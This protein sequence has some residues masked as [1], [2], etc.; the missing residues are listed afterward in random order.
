MKSTVWLTHFSGILAIVSTLMGQQSP[1]NSERGAVSTYCNPLAI[2]DYPIGKRC[3]DIVV[4]APQPNNSLWLLDHMEQYRELADV[5]VLWHEGKWYMYPSVDMAWVSSDGGATWEHHPLNVRDIGYAPTVVRHKGKF[6][7]L[8]SGSPIYTSDSPL[9]PFIELGKI[10]VPQGLPNQTDPMLFS[11][12]DGRLYYYWG[13]TAVGGIY[14]VELDADNPT[15]IAGTPVRLV[16]RFEPERFP[17]QRLGDWNEDANA[18]YIEGAWLLKRNGTYYLTYSAGGTENRTYAVGCLTSKAPLGPFTPQKDNP[19]MRN[20]N[21]LVTGTAHGS[22]VEGP[23]NSLWAFYTLRAGAVHGWERRLGMDPAYISED[24]E[25]HVKPAS[26]LP[27]R[28]TS[29]NQGAEPTGWVPL[30]ANRRSGAT[31]TAANLSTRL[32]VDDDL[33][34]WWQPEA[35]DKAPALTTALVGNATVHAIRIVW[36]DVGINTMKGASPGAFRYKVE[37]QTAPNTWTTVIDRSDSKDDLLIDYR[38]CAPTKGNSARLVIVGAPDGIT[39]G[40]AEF[41]V[42]GQALRR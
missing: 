16:D 23:N 39:P 17:W 19:I 24:G 15:R 25:L 38:E 34:T 40:V 8:A 14:G 6:L 42:F 5:S 30:N 1:P 41:T 9:G 13:C 28:L 11:D 37:L 12:D 2:P 27:Q 22:F 32:A 3:R 26:S 31:S 33:R 7:L 18:G 36:R 20:I 10:T 21:G 35:A 29:T 4:G